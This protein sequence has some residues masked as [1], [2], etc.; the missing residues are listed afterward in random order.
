MTQTI[1]HKISGFKGT[2]S[3]PGDKSI[4]H[5]ALILSSQALGT[6]RITGL[7]EGEDVIATADALGS[8][9][10]DIEQTDGAWAVKGVGIGG[11]AQPDDVIDCGNS[12]TSAR[13]LMGLVA[14]YP[15][16]SFFT[17][18]ASLRK[19]PMNR[20]VRPLTEMGVA[21][22]DNGDGRLP[23][24]LKGSASTLPIHYELPV[25]SAQVKSAILLAALNTAGQTT[26]IEPAATRDHTEKMLRYF[27]VDI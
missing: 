24:A 16:T 20:V 5:R 23:L 13:L 17:G 25:A 19:R 3:V 14:P 1:S 21:F 10:V 12:G 11:L 27:G 26:V 2:A 9:G 15:F 22:V 8:M 7:L 6:T 4:S 18:D